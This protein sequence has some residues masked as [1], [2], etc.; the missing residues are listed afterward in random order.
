[1]S[2]LANS[3]SPAAP[4]AT[5]TVTGVLE[6]IIF[7]NE[8][9]HYTIGELRPETPAGTG[10]GLVTI[11]GALP[12]VQCGETLELS[13]AWATHREHGRQFKI[14]SFRSKLPAS[15][16][17]IRK[18]LGSGLV[19]GI[20][21]T[22]AEKIVA[23]FGAETLKIISEQSVRLR[24]VPGIGAGRAKAIKKAW[25]EQQ[26]MRDVMMFLQ[27]YGVTTG[28]CLRIVK[29]YGAFARMVVE[30]EPYKV[31]REIEGIGFH[32]ADK[33]ARNLGLPTEGAARIDAGLLFALGETEE[34]GHTAVPSGKLVAHTAAMLGAPAD[35]IAA[36]VARLLETRQLLSLPPDAAPADASA[37]LQTPQHARAEEEI[38]ACAARLL[39]H[40]GALPPVHVDRAVAWAQDKA[41]FAFAPAQAEAVRVAL[42]RKFSILTGGPGTGKTTILRALCDILSAKKARIVLAA[43]TGRAAQRMSETTRLPASTIHRLLKYDPARGRF[44]HDAS[45]PV[46]ADI[47]VVDEASMLDNRLGAALLRAVHAATHLLLVGDTHQLPS[48]GPGNVLQDL[49]ASRLFPVTT[50]EAIFRQG[51]RSRIVRLAHDIL[52]GDPAPPPVLADA[53]ALDPDAEVQ[54]ISAPDPAACA[55]QV[56]ALCRHHL[57]AKLRLDP[58]RDIQ[59]LAPMHKGT[60][61]IQ[62][63]NAA[64]QQALKPAS[65]RSLAAGGQGGVRFEEGDKII[66][67]RNNYDKGVF[68]GDLGRVAS[69]NPETGALVA[70][71]DGTPVNYDRADLGELQLA[72]AITIHKSQGSEFDTV[73]IPLLKSHYVMLQRNLIYTAV[74]R[75]RKRVILVGDPAAYAMAVNNTESTRRLTA[76]PQKLGVACPP[77]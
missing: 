72:Y 2:D 30:S 15:V 3:T 16:H 22:Y 55:A 51:A 8:E 10:A 68:N 74:T 23:R 71:F 35:K 46:H 38:A 42:T 9:N 59:V 57:A 77:K 75:G 37:L 63:L 14:T 24:E 53:A 41:G 7:F 67:T 47:L 6:R 49:I 1:V 65:A 26:A 17:G 62:S 40:P 76:L 58:F 54:F 25:D 73:V 4:T 21:K 50:L 13:G 32:T 64:L 18:Y 28:Q 44:V 34:E 56:T 29:T 43:P 69:V 12:G 66:Q 60:A 5:A 19:P 31:A 20:G 70:D 27:T 36:G 45:N 33:I 48:V 61:G 39:A 52:R 11:L